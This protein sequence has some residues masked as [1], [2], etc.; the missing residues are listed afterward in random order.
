M[1][2]SCDTVQLYTHGQLRQYITGYSTH[3]WPLIGGNWIRIGI[4]VKR[5]K[6]TFVNTDLHVDMCLKKQDR[7]HFNV[8]QDWVE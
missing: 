8:K 1:G 6:A 3:Y 7:I 4:K 5:I 2:G